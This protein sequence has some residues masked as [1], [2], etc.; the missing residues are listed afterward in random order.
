MKTESR[1]ALHL[2]SCPLHRATKGVHPAQG[3]GPSTTQPVPDEPS[4][5]E[6]RLHP[7]HAVHVHGH[8]DTTATV[9]HLERELDHGWE[10]R[11]G[12][13]LTEQVPVLK[14]R[15]LRRKTYPS[16]AQTHLEEPHSWLN[17]PILPGK[18]PANSHLGEDPPPWSILP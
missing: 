18:T 7:V 14:Y 5:G 13:R 17:R 8:L 2:Q 4:G 16:V 11:S 6:R 3:I 9:V 1:A 12:E 15:V 10:T